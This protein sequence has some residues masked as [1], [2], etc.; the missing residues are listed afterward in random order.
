M[1]KEEA[2]V[3]DFADD[4]DFEFQNAL[5]NLRYYQDGDKKALSGFLY[6]CFKNRRRAPQWVQD[7]FCAAFKAVMG[8][9]AK[10]WDD[11]LGR[12]LKKGQHQHGQRR[13]RQLGRKILARVGDRRR[14][15]EK[16]DKALFDSVAKEFGIQG[17]LAADIYY[18]ERAI[19]HS[20]DA[21]FREIL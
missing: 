3:G 18:E 8:Y 10:S 7:E 1:K 6:L 2:E 4:D 19:V 11:V 5:F 20:D 21:Y 16:I 13:R 14:A 12:R 9:E 15:G 17:T